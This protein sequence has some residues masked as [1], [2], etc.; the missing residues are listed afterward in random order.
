VTAVTYIVMGM[1]L[2]NLIL[3]TLGLAPVLFLAIGV[4]VGQPNVKSVERI[5]KDIKISVDDR[6]SD[7]LTVTL[8]GGPGVVTVADILPQSF[9]LEEGTNFR[10]VWKSLAP[11]TLEFGYMA[12][13]AKRGYF[14]IKEVDYEVRHPLMINRNILGTINVKRAIVVQP[15]P[16]F[17]RKIKN[18]KN[19]SRVP[20]PKDAR[21]HFGISTTDFREIRDYQNTDSFRTINWKAS[22]KKLSLRPGKFM[23]NEYEKEGKKVV[24]IFLDSAAHMALG[25]TV[26]NTM[27]Y[28]IRAAIG[29]TNFYVERD[30]RVG[31]CVYDTDA[32]QWEGTFLPKAVK[33]PINLDGLFNIDQIEQVE[34]EETTGLPMEHRRPR[35][36][37]IFPDVGKRQQYKITREMLHVDINYSTESLKEAVHSCRRYII[38]SQPLFVIITM[39]EPRKLQGIIDGIRELHR[40][41]G[42]IGKPSII[43]FNVQGYK[44]AAQTLEEKMAAG[45]LTYHNKPYYDVLRSMGCIVVNWDPIG[46]S[47]AQ[48]LQRQK[49]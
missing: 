19:I 11:K 44:I 31:F 27:E 21:F 17:V 2:G 8:D 4:L 41:L 49:M 16:L 23:V 36:R 9:N 38:G 46:E 20:M 48:A 30:C 10:A 35:S 1:F 3:I 45:F 12:I 37:V 39:V 7:R 28:A 29:F 22:A 47:F 25:T 24:W 42:R 40:Y 33:E 34:T 26:N 18:H 32:Y 13:C 5:G 15:Q 14:D 43:L 6:I